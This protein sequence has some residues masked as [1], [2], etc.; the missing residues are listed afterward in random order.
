M[1]VVTT[2]WTLRPVLAAWARAN[3]IAVSTRST[4]SLS[5]ALRCK[6]E[7]PKTAAPINPASKVTAKSSSTRVK[8]PCRDRDW[9]GVNFID[10]I[11]W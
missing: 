2:T 6:L 11:I 1:V 4:P 3:R 5:W 8:P 10:S 7:N 9:K